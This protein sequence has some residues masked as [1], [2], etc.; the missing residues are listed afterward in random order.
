MVKGEVDLDFQCYKC[1]A[2]DQQA[3]ANQQAAEPE[4]YVE[5]SDLQEAEDQQAEEPHVET[6]DQ[7]V[8]AAAADS[9]PLESTRLPLGLQDRTPHLP[10]ISSISERMNATYTVHPG[11]SDGHTAHPSYEIPAEVEE[12]SLTNA[13]FHPEDFSASFE[14]SYEVVKGGTKRGK[15]LLVDSQGYTYNQRKARCE[16][17][18]QWECTVGSKHTRCYATVKQFNYTFTR[19][20][21]DHCH[22]PEKGTLIRAK[23]SSAAKQLGVKE[24]FTSAGNTVQDLIT[25]FRDEPFLPKPQNLIRSTNLFRQ[26]TRAKDPADLTFQIN[27]EY[28]GEDFFREDIKV[29]GRQHLL[30]STSDHM[31]LLAKSR[32]F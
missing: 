15:D 18:V 30:F 17:K 24:V 26:K 10:D 9:N 3:A 23:I 6:D 1:L 4:P 29:N 32:V 31:K 14:I 28:V 25:E 22:P 20:N 7:Q 16:Y 27:K 8:A 11:D 21:K 19:G 13:T 12:T 5:T 2:S